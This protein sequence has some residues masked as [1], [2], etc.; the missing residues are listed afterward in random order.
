MFKAFGSRDVRGFHNLGYYFGSPHNKDCHIFGLILGSSYFGKL[1]F[2]YL[3]GGN[4]ARDRSAHKHRPHT[5]C[6]SL[7]K[8]LFP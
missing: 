8:G 1:P 4:E 3:L 7:P 6:W 5:M 2:R